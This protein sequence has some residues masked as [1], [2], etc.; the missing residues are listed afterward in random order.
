MAPE[1]DSPSEEST[2]VRGQVRS[3]EPA[4]P[5]YTRY[6]LGMVLLTMIFS[7]VDRTILSILVDPIKSEF[8]LSDTQM[9]FLLGPAFA[10]VY[11]I[12]VLP[13][14]R[15]ADTTGVRRNIVSAA[16]FLWSL[17]TVATGFVGTHFQLGLMRMG[18]GVGEAGATS[19]SISMISD[20]LPP[21]RRVALLGA[22]ERR[23]RDGHG[24]GEV[25]AVS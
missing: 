15:Y 11:S 4:T 20:Y 9:G 6:V 1:T 14:G 25:R 10:V 5:L 8:G 24:L 17:F 2:P 21:E 18:V 19:P 7:N 16:L 12:L 22:R 3:A 13:I 23:H